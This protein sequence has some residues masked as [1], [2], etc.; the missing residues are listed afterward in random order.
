MNLTKE[1]LKKWGACSDGYEWY[2]K[3]KEPK[4]VESTIKKLI[5][6]DKCFDWANWLLPKILDK[7]NLI[8]YA[9]FAAE[10]VL[11]IYE[12]KHPADDRPRKA[13]EVAK[14]YLK[15]KTPDASAAALA[16]SDAAWA[17]ASDAAWAARAAALAASD[18]ARAAALA[19]RAATR[20]A[21]LAARAATS[22][23]AWAARAA[24][25][26]ASDAASDAALAAARAAASD[27]A[28]DAAESRVYKKIINYGLKLI[29]EQ[30]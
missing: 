21:A 9:I 4:T 12:N 5:A 18:A 13:I 15:E 22:D 27:A 3:N 6:D 8:R 17:A 10:L 26:A 1:D 28:S 29:K 30:K 14:N 20:A 23:A 24:A 7:N 11:S 16:A 2:L 25:L 19:A